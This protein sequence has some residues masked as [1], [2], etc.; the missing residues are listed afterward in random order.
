MLGL[1]KQM[2]L[3]LQLLQRQQQKHKQVSK[4]ILQNK[5]DTDDGSGETKE[6]D[7]MAVAKETAGT[8]AGSK[9][10]LQRKHTY[11]IGMMKQRRLI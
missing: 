9:K 8:E 3:I 1:V 2:R 11:M 10:N 4:K 5:N 6:V 7:L